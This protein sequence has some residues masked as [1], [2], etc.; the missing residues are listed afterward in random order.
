MTCVV[1]VVVVAFRRWLGRIHNDYDTNN[2]FKKKKLHYYI[3]RVQ[4][5]SE[6]TTSTPGNKAG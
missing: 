3:G 6:E 1:V 5:G 4:G 2:D